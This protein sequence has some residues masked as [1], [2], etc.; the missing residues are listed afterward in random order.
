MAALPVIGLIGAIVATWRARR[1]ARALAAWMPVALFTAFACAM[2][3]WQ[4]RAGPAAQLLAVPGATALG[5]ALF[6]WLLRRASLP[7]ALVGTVIAFL[8]VSGLFAGMIVRW[9]KVDPPNATQ[10]MVSRA[11]RRCG[12]IP[13]MKPLDRLPAQTVFTHVDLG[14][15]LIVLT[16]HDA[17]AGPYHRN[18][19]AIL[20]VHHAFQRSAADF[21]RIAKAHGATLLL[22]CPNMAETTVYRARSPNGFYAQLMRGQEPDFLQPVPLPGHSPFKLWRIR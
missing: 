1:D 20:D 11:N 8:L 9:G 15:R 17:I 13:A 10:Q 14:P 6:P 12:T 7:V 19:D 2:L 5:W 16:H 4:I 21:H 22:V 18:G 3:L